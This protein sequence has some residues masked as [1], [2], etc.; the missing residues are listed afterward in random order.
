MT[1]VGW[2]VLGLMAKG[3]LP[4]QF[5]LRTE[6]M[7]PDGVESDELS[8]MCS[9]RQASHAS[10]TFL[11]F[12]CPCI[13]CVSVPRWGGTPASTCRPR[14]RLLIKFK[15]MLN[16]YS[17]YSVHACTAAH[18]TL[19]LLGSLEDRAA[20]LLVQCALDIGQRRSRGRV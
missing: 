8:Y 18:G 13:S 3:K 17:D 20:A 11:L 1:P 12:T 9:K 2:P 7:Q 10:A 6:L 19:V 15:E 14:S 16:D 5:Q 4:A